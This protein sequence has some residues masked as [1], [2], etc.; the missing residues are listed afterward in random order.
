MAELAPQ[1]IP[2]SLGAYAH[3]LLSS[4]DLTE[5]LYST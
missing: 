2:H 3:P 5:L 1:R 4:I